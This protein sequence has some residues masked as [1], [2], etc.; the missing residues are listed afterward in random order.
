MWVQGEQ[1]GFRGS[2]AIRRA[3]DGELFFY[4]KVLSFR[5]SMPDGLEP[6]DV[7]NA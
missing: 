7:V 2:N 4:G 6:P 3:L 5:A 1:H